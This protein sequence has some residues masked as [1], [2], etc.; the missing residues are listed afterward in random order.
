MAW[1]VTFSGELNPITVYSAVVATGVA[2]WQVFTYLRDGPR[3]KVSVGTNMKIAG[4]GRID[5]KTYVSFN[6]TNIGK[7]D[8]TVTSVGYYVFDTPWKKFRRK[9]SAAFIVVT[10]PPGHSVPHVLEP[11]KTFMALCDQTEELVGYTKGRRLYGVISH[12][13]GREYLVRLPTIEEKPDLS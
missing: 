11:G 3:L 7:G 10:G 1:S 4:G 2:M 5:P 13:M 6:V 12:S 8:T 9:S